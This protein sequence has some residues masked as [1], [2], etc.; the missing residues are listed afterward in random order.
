MSEPLVQNVKRV[1]GD[2]YPEIFAVTTNGAAQNINGWSFRLA[3]HSVP[4]PVDDTTLVFLMTGSVVDEVAGTVGF[5]PSAPQAATAPGTYYFDVEAVEASGS[6]RTT[7]K[8]KW[9]ISQDRT[10]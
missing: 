5:T 6:I 7:T 8:G 4:D 1:R 9:V 10:K 3:V 2:T